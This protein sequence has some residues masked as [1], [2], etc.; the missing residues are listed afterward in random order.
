MVCKVLQ[1][2]PPFVSLTSFSYQRHLA[3]ATAVLWPEEAHSH[4]EAFALAFLSFWN[5]SS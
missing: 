5:A 1:L 3:A 2:L 4:F